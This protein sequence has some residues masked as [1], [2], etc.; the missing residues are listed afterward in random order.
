MRPVSSIR[1]ARYLPNSRFAITED[2][3]QAQAFFSRFF[4]AAI[5]HVVLALLLYRFRPTLPTIYVMLIFLA[6]LFTLRDKTPVRL[7]YMCAYIASA[8]LLWRMT[9]AN[10]F[11]ESGKYLLVLLMFLGAVRWQTR[12]QGTAILYFSLLIPGVVITLGVLDL[13]AAR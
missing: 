7:I 6:V 12:L 2:Q 3:R 9:K 8:E 10:V 13:S 5:L 11:W 1:Q 4:F